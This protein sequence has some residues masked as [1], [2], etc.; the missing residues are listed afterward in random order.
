[1]QGLIF[2][3]AATA[4]GIT[5]RTRHLIC[6]GGAVA[7]EAPKKR[8][9]AP[10]RWTRR[11]SAGTSKRWTRLS[12]GGTSAANATMYDAAAVAA[13]E[14]R[15][16]ASTPQRP[17]AGFA[18]TTALLADGCGDVAQLASRLE[19]TYRLHVA[20]LRARAAKAFADALDANDSPERIAE[21]AVEAEFAFADEIERCTSLHYETGDAVEAFRDTVATIVEDALAAQSLESLQMSDGDLPSRRERLLAFVREHKRFLWRGGALLLNIVQARVA[22]RQARKAAE[23]RDREQP[24]IPLF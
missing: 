7:V 19:P 23:R 1:M 9:T 21:Q 13:L 2:T 5:P 22:A 14:E 3:L 17:Y 12:G 18:E 24:K 11:G 8:T 15:V 20:V 4:G 16:A 10:P 6:R